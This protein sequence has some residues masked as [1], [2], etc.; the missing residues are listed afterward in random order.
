MFLYK[1]IFQIL[2][3]IKGE[4][5]KSQRI[6][7][8]EQSN[9]VSAPTPNQAIKKLVL[10][11]IEPHQLLNVQIIIEGEITKVD[12]QGIHYNSNPNGIKSDRIVNKP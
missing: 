8:H 9:L 1:I 4:D 6:Y 5:D 7:V 11:K 2:D 3:E 12:K 10:P